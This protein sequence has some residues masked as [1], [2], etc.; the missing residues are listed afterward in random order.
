[1]LTADL[2]T[3]RRR[4]DELVL[5]RSDEARV[6][7]IAAL[8]TVLSTAARGQIG[9]T[10]EAVEETLDRVVANEGGAAER[11][12]AAGVRKLVLDGCRFEEPDPEAA[13]AL[14]REL[15]RRAA[16]ARRAA[17][18]TAPFDRAAVMQA[19]AV[20]RGTTAEALEGGLYGD[21]PSAQRL[22]A[23]EL[24]RP[25]ALAA[26]FS[27]AEA[28][29]V[30]LRATQVRATVRA[31][32]A[33][34]YR[35]LFRRLKFLRL[36]PAISRTP[37]G[38]V[39]VALDGPLSLFQGG[40][41]YGLA[42]ALALP[43]IAACDTWAIDA[44][45]RWGA[46]RRPLRFRLA[47]TAT[48]LGVTTPAELPEELARLLEAFARLSSDWDVHRE[49]SVLDLPGAGLCVPDLTFVRRRD[50]ARVHFELLGFWSREAV[51]RRVELVRAG[52]PHRILFAASRQLRVGEVVLEDNPT[53]ALYVFTRVLAAKE[54]LA[55]LEQLA[56]GSSG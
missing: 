25:A 12:L 2:A 16:A 35:H 43:A 3:V 49:P 5:V 11:R 21:R 50:G 4:G 8:A 31:G 42:L 33:A 24:P 54:V 10:R 48:D 29:A 34:T 15:F 38:A 22:L 47:G 46:E 18:P 27:I 39:H 7:T 28:Q 41:R 6:E 52:L 37:E 56:S 13:T 9:E 17:T 36:L 51:W 26:G 40:T 30:L 44:D 14:R 1:V 32:D 53:A 45:V 55:R 19:E 20:T 23:V